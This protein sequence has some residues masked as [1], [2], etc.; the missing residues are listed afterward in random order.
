M[1]NAA[2][3]SLR[4]A[5]RHVGRCSG[6]FCKPPRSGCRRGDPFCFFPLLIWRAGVV[7]IGIWKLSHWHELMREGDRVQWSTLDANGAYGYACV[8]VQSWTRFG[9][10]ARRSDIGSELNYLVYDN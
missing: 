4:W 6:S 9:R 2:Y 5:V 7:D 10:S 8:A 3:I 1:G